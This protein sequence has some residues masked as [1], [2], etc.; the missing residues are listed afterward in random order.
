MVREC[1]RLPSVA[2]RTKLLNHLFANPNPDPLQRS[3]RALLVTALR[4]AKLWP[5]TTG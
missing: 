4:E 2:A 3:R 5:S 1:R